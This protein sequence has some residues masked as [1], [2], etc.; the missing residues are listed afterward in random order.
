MKKVLLVSALAMLVFITVSCEKVKG[1]GDVVSQNRDIRDYSGISLSLDADVYY[2]PG[3]TWS[4]RIDAQQ[5]IIDVIET[6]VENGKVVL[7]YENG[8]VIGSHDQV[9]VYIT[10]PDLSS[11]IVNGSGKIECD[12][13]WY[14][15][16]AEMIISGS[17]SLYMDY[18]NTS[19]LKCNISGSGNI[20]AHG[21]ITD[22]SDLNISGSGNMYLFNVVSDTTYSTISGSGNMEVNVQKFLDATISGSGN[23]TYMG[24]PAVNVHI[25]GSGSVIKH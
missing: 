2:T 20:E 25:S 3:N 15:P 22:Y 6:P 17:G 10:A 8:K 24:N 1:K 12:S 18:I 7:K 16:S 5:N 23:I 11:F 19:N 4:F 9:T 14:V 13:L 21:G